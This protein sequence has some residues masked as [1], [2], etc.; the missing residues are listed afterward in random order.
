VRLL[1]LDPAARDVQVI[2]ELLLCYPGLGRLPC[3]A[4]RRVGWVHVLVTW[5]LLSRW[6]PVSGRIQIVDLMC[7]AIAHTLDQSTEN[8]DEQH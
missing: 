2:S 8:D 7:V 5:T 1:E 6:L 4:T 3:N